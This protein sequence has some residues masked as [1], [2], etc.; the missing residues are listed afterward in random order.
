MVT[1]KHPNV[2]TR[3]RAEVDRKI[4]KVQENKQGQENTLEWKQ[5][6]GTRTT[7]SMEQMQE[8]VW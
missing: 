3:D 1:S 2:E 7:G 4:N 6:Q 5:K 8:Q